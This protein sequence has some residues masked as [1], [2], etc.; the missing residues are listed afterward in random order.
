M[1]DLTFFTPGTGEADV[2]AVKELYD[3]IYKCFWDD[4]FPNKDTC[5]YKVDNR[6]FKIMLGDRDLQD[7]K[8]EIEV[9]TVTTSNNIY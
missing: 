5:L 1:L 4:N 2:R 3:K 9:E 7:L 8:I 6:H